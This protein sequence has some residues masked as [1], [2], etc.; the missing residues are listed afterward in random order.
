MR[1]HDPPPRPPADGPPPAAARPGPAALLRA[2]AD[3]LWPAACGGCARPGP[4]WCPA[5]ARALA[6]GPRR[7]ELADGTALV[8]AAAHA[9]PARELLLEVK[10]R[11]RAELRPVAAAALAGAVGALV[12]GAPPGA[13]LPLVP[14]PSRRASRRE[15]GGDLVADL[16]ARAAAHRRA[17]GAPTAVV[18]ALRVRR[19]VVDQ[20]LLGARERRANLAGAFAVRGPVP[21]GPCV[22]VDDVATTTA[23]AAEA[24]RALRAAGARVLGVACLTAAAPA[25]RAP[26]RGGPP[27]S[28]WAEAAVGD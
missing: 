9:G 15:R 25:A 3:L 12:D 21:P 5:C 28:A 17:A 10:E 1:P 23:T 13:P 14:V 18:R 16:A 26:G 7:L 22:V 11:H 2:A 4:V 8:A 19:R 27:P 24:V 6:A 20:T